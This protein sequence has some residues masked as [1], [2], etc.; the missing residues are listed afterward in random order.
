MF[1][2]YLKQVIALFIKIQQFNNLILY[3]QNSFFRSIIFV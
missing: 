3:L 2:K 1:V